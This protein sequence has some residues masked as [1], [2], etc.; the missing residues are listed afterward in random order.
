M[1]STM[2]VLIIEDEKPLASLL[3]KVLG[4]TYAVDAYSSGKEG[5]LMAARQVYDVIILDLGLPDVDGQEVCVSMRQ[6]GIKTPILVLSGRSAL[7]DKIGLFDGGADDYLVKPASIIEIKARIRAL[8]R[9]P[10]E[11]LVDDDINFDDLVLNT[12]YRTVSR[13]GIKIELRRKEFELLGYLMRNSSRVVTREQIISNVWDN[14]ADFFIN[15]IDV[16]IMHLRDK[17]DLP[18]D[19]KLIKTIHGVGYKMESHQKSLSSARS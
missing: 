10:Q 1:P 18:F 6:A 12:H 3:Q 5:L 15:N 14:N 7:N 11:I 9:R 4:K 8:L 17:V 16:H 2:R 13:G 19:R